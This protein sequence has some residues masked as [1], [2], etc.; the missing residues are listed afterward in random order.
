M[1][2]RL[3]KAASAQAKATKPAPA[4]RLS[5]PMAPANPPPLGSLDVMSLKGKALK[6]YALRAGVP[7]RDVDH[8]T[9]DRL[10][11]NTRMQITHHFELL[12]EA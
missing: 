10:R 6:D 12:D 1:P 2:R 11:Q 8:L 4:V 3:G 5:S 7:Q 9:E